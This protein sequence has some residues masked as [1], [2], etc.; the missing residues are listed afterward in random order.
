MKIKSIETLHINDYAYDLS[1]DSENHTYQLDNGV[2]VHNCLGIPKQ[3]MGFTE[4]GAGFNGGQ[5][6]SIISSTFAKRVKRFQ[7]AYCQALTDAINLMLL[8]AGLDSY[9]NQFTIRMQAPTTQEEETRTAEV[10]NQMGL[11]RDVMDLL[12]DVQEIPVKLAIVKELLANIITNPEVIQIL[13]DYIDK[14]EAEGGEETLNPNMEDEEMDLNLN[15]EE[16]T[17]YDL[18]NPS[19]LD[20]ALGLETNEESPLEGNEE[21]ALPENETSLPTPSELNIGDLTNNNN[22]EI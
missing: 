21:V 11:A 17:N 19:D 13:Q 16:P 9:V 7:N 6:L 22:P 15:I 8:D 2:F 3:Y 18:G 20:Q 1:V 12:N 4:D 10:A 5:S 14:L